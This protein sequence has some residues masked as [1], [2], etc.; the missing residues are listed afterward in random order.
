MPEVLQDPTTNTTTVGCPKLSGAEFQKLVTELRK[1]IDT[2]FVRASDLSRAAFGRLRT[3][4][5]SCLQAAGKEIGCE[6]RCE[7]K[8]KAVVITLSK[9][10]A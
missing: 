4:P 10:A 3:I 1:H 9:L 5:I 2:G 8:E 7:S 6:V